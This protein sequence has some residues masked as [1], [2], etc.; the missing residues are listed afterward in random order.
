MPDTPPQGQPVGDSSGDVP[1]EGSIDDLLADAADLAA[2]LG[3]EVG[4]D[5]PAGLES[6]TAPD[7]LSQDDLDQD[8]IDAQLEEIEKLLDS[9]GED[10]GAGPPTEGATVPRQPPAATQEKTR[11]SSPLPPPTEDNEGSS[12]PTTPAENDERP[13]PQPAQS[14]ERRP[15]PAPAVTEE[16][17]SSATAPPGAGMPNPEELARS[18]ST[19]ECS[20]EDNDLQSPGDNLQGTDPE[21]QPASD[22]AAAGPPAATPIDEGLD[23]AP[24]TTGANCTLLRAFD[25]AADVLD[26]LDRP[27]AWI[28][29]DA[30]RLIGWAALATF[31]AA[32]WIFVASRV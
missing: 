1:A 24:A 16:P 23:Q 32:G 28:G 22:D 3:D 11:S 4:A 15:S 13:S 10:L 21:V 19:P 30:R 8:T 18:E 14:D 17:S 26:L 5:P 27:F 2:S 25:R 31:A 6:S 20:P 9:A 7:P 12:A 29:C